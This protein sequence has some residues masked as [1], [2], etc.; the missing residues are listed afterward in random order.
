VPLAAATASSVGVSGT[1]STVAVYSDSPPSLSRTVPLTVRVPVS[2]VGQ[3]ALA[4]E[5][6]VP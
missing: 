2:E 4:A 5:L 3:E 6:K 1:I